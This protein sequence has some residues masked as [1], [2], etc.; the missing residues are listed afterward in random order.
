M[1]RQELKSANIENGSAMTNPDRIPLATLLESSHGRIKLELIAHA[2]KQ[3]AVFVYPTE[4]IYGI[5]GLWSVKGVKEKI[6]LIKQRA[7]DQPMILI[8]SDRSCFSKLPVLFPP[9]AE[10]LARRFWPGKLTMVLPSP[11]TEEGISIRVSNHPFIKE[12]FRYIDQPLYS[13]SANRTGKEYFNDPERI[14]SDFSEKI[15]FF[16]DAGPLP[17]SLPSTVVKIGDDD[18]IS[19]IREGAVSSRDIFKTF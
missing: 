12:I 13:T 7:P 11:E 2:V 17:Q 18:S 14:Y 4:T 8:A 6:I 5:G 10:L 16:V 1:R 19:I 15:D 3:G 9:S